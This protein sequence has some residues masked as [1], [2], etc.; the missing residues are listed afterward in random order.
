MHARVLTRLPLINL[1][2]HPESLDPGLDPLVT[3]VVLGYVLVVC[4][5][6]WRRG[7]CPGIILA[8]QAP[9]VFEFLGQNLKILAG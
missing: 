9:W 2:P 8:F 7:T 1:L 4:A 3:S 6:S 5:T